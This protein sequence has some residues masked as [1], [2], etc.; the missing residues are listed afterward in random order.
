MKLIVMG[1]EDELQLCIVCGCPFTD[2]YD[3]HDNLGFEYS[4]EGQRM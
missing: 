3:P 1:D 4:F 2:A